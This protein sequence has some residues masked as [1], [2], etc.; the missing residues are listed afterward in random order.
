MRW[1]KNVEDEMT[2]LIRAGSITRKAELNVMHY[3]PPRSMLAA[4]D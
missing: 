2:G 3:L 4:P 1:E